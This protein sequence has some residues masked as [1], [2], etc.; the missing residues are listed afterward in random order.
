MASSFSA[1]TASAN[2][3]VLDAG[4]GEG[5]LTRQLA[6]RQSLQTHFFCGIDLSKDGILQAAREPST[7]LWTVGDLARLPFQK[8]TFHWVLNI[9]SPANYK[10]FARVLKPDGILLKV[11][12]GALYLK[13]I[14][15]VMYQGTKGQSYDNARIKEHFEKH[16][17]WMEVHS[18]TYTLTPD[19]ETLKDLLDMTPLLM[20]RTPDQNQWAE[21]KKIQTWC[22]DYEIILGKMK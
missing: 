15:D 5:S 17:H 6:A 16:M 1:S 19:E 4:C 21:L 8:E 7:I 3:I 10:E 12:P 20:D 11:V 14:R 22:L 13:S 9:L 18:L 2:R